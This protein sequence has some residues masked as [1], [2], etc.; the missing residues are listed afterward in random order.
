M[1]TNRNVMSLEEKTLNERI[2]IFRKLAG[3]TQETAAELLEMK[4]N[5]YARMEKYGNPKPD[6]ILKMAQ[7]YNVSINMILLGTEEDEREQPKGNNSGNG[8][9]E[10]PPT[11]PVTQAPPV[12][13]PSTFQSPPLAL[14]SL[15]RSCVEVMRILPKE[16]RTMIVEYINELYQEHK[17][18]K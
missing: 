7:L 6:V 17:G 4:K 1:A 2:A 3:Y 8:M 15:E 5:T 9:G 11:E 12:S 18:R 16:K 13:K 14:T 10:V